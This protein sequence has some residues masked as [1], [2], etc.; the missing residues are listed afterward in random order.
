MLTIDIQELSRLT[1]SYL[2][3]VVTARATFV[4]D[5]SLP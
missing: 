5:S 3:I 4:L 2:C 1:L